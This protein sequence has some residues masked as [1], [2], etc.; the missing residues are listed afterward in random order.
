[1][2]RELGEMQQRGF[3]KE[4]VSD[5]I[6]TLVSEAMSQRTSFERNFKKAVDKAGLM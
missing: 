2:E 3:T 1:M 5:I 4:N 6:I